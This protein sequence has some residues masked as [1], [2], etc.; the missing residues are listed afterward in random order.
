MAFLPMTR[1]GLILRVG[2][3]ALVA[4]LVAACG[5]ASGATPAAPPTSAAPPA[6]KPTTGPVTTPAAAVVSR[7]GRV[8]LPTYVP[9][10]APPPDIPG[11]GM[12]PPGYSAY[13][14]QITRSVADRPAKGG[15]ITVVTQTL[16]VVPPTPDS[17]PIWAE[18]NKRIGANLNITITP[19]ADYGTKLPTILA[20]NDLPDL[21]FLPR[22]Q[23]VPGFAQFL[24]SQAADLTP[25]LSGDAVKDY[26]NLRLG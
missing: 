22:G 16:G 25:Y 11:T 9:P 8:S 7:S 10:N 17:N 3:T 1:R 4:Q 18:L 19:F 2:G 15:D 26:P 24:D 12:V 21:L 6:P 23:R 13:P 5:G 20:G 14:K